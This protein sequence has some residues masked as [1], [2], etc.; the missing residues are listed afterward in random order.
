VRSGKL[1]RRHGQIISLSE[2]TFMYV[3]ETTFMYVCETTFMCIH[4]FSKTWSNAKMAYV[5]NVD[6]DEW[7]NHGIHNFSSWDHLGFQKL[8]CSC[9]NFKI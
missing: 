4:N 1:L 7:N 8:A 5:S 6:L 3:C 9:Q 2:S